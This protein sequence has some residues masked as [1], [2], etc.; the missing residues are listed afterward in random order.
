MILLIL[1]MLPL[2]CVEASLY[3]MPQKVAMLF[4]QEEEILRLL[5]MVNMTN[6]SQKVLLYLDSC[7]S[8]IEDLSVPDVLTKEAS[9]DLLVGNPVHVYSLMDC[10]VNLLPGVRREL[11]ECGSTAHIAET[12]R[13]LLEGVELPSQDDMQGV[14]LALA[15]IQFVY[16]YTVHTI[17]YS[18]YTGIQ[19]TP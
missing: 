6:R 1:H 17:G 12:L 13:T 18:L 5:M 10:L 9:V 8:R 19:Y 11:V 16:R 2:V 14:S 4:K 3:T 15:R 7:N